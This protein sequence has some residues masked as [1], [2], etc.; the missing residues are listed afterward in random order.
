MM[1]F[2]IDVLGRRVVVVERVGVE[3]V[4]ESSVVSARDPRDSLPSLAAL[5]DTLTP[6]PTTDSAA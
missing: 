1:E 3:S 4:V 5:A 6:T 2:F